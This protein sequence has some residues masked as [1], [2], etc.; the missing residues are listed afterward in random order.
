MLGR[1]RA[2]VVVLAM[3]T[4]SCAAVGE[5]ASERPDP[6]TTPSL[7]AATSEPTA[8]AAVVAS[9]EPASEPAE[10][11]IGDELAGVG[12]V[13]PPNR[14]VTAAVWLADPSAA[15]SVLRRRAAYAGEATVSAGGRVA[16]SV[17]VPSVLAVRVDPHD[18]GPIGFEP[19]TAGPYVV[20]LDPSGS[21]DVLAE[22]L[23]AE[24][25]PPVGVHPIEPIQP[26][27]ALGILGADHLAGVGFGT[28][29]LDAIDELTRL[30]G[31]P[32][33][34]T[35]WLDGC[36]PDRTLTWGA[37]QAKFYPT[38]DPDGSD[39]GVRLA[40][41]PTDAGEFASFSYDLSLQTRK[42]GSHA[43]GWTTT[44][45]IG[46]GATMAEIRTAYPTVEFWTGYDSLVADRW[47]TDD[48]VGGLLSIDATS[49]KATVTAI[50][51]PG[52]TVFIT[53]C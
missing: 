14:A 12:T 7:S 34:D 30:L 6:S 46:I 38:A 23:V 13:F 52:L 19:V 21:F 8:P 35:G 5:P 42:G 36:P 24:D 27:T 9:D 16:W 25:G 41:L 43:A 50:G 18:S 11:T 10:L 33:S 48:G 37:L 29:I 49:E 53:V 28:P 4:P 2:T 22:V 47:I 40:D 3:L 39:R 26:D 32:D 20:S 31:P 15:G 51:S 1:G 17:V 45:G 44:S